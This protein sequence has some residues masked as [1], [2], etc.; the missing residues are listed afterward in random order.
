[1]QI[2]AL[3]G[4]ALGANIISLILFTIAVLTAKK[5]SVA[6]WVLFA[7]G[8]GWGGL[9]LFAN[10]QNMRTYPSLLGPAGYQTWLTQY[11]FAC[12]VFLVLAA[13]TV[14]MIRKRTKK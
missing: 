4:Y 13:V 14:R 11:I 2:A 6:A 7:V 3:A 10:G 9:T 5:S 8:A 12:V 1:M